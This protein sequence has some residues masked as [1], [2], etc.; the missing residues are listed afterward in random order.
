[1]RTKGRPKGSGDTNVIGLRRR[2]AGAEKPKPFFNLSPT[3]Q[4][5]RKLS[6]FINKSCVFYVLIKNSHSTWYV[7]PIQLDMLNLLLLFLFSMILVGYLLCL[8]GMLHCFL[9]PTD[10]EMALAGG[11]VGEEK[12]ETRPRKVPDS[13][14]DENVSIRLIQKYFEPDAWLAVEH[15][16]SA[17]QRTNRWHCG[18]CSNIWKGLSISCDSC[19]RWFD[20]SCGL[21]V[22]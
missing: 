14:L 10:V 15:V 8:V 13:V 18:T 3:E 6:T 2:R 12:V 7:V 9:S 4:E 11:L 17:K 21:L 16:M 1:M 19:L 5:K 20:Y 22:A